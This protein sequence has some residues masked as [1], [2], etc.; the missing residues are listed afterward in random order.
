MTD[1]LEQRLKILR[2]QGFDPKNILD[3]GA[4]IGTLSQ[5]AHSIWP[6]ASIVMVEANHDCEKALRNRKIGDVEI[7]LLG[8]KNAPSVKYFSSRKEYITGNS[9]YLEQ[10]SY[11]SQY[12]VRLLPMM[13]LTKLARVR[14]WNAF[15]LIKIDTQGS[16]RDII[17][18][19]KMLIQKAK[20]VCLETQVLEYN[21]HA[22]KT[23]EMM[24][25]MEKLGFQLFDITN[26]Q[27]LPTGEMAQLDMIF[28]PKTSA[29]I[30]RGVLW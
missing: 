17:F 4:H 9:I 23:F 13:T 2:W 24:Q 22:P 15:D 30:K 14:A 8:N 11:F 10:T 1:V 18:G 27:T 21:A 5:L 3:I 16:E 25:L 20:I 28:V 29:F 7:V 19:G 26:I 12:E 6:K